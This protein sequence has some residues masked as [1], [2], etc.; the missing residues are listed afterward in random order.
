MKLFFKYIKRYRCTPELFEM[1]FLNG[2]LYPR[3]AQ[4]IKRL[5][6]IGLRQQMLYSH[7][8][9]VQDVYL[10]A[11]RK[12]C[13]SVRR[14]LGFLVVVI[15]PPQSKLKLLLFLWKLFVVKMCACLV[16]SVQNSFLQL[17]LC[18]LTLQFLNQKGIT[19][20]MMGMKK[21]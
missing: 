9:S 11:V 13:S 8:V 15:G 20:N 6:P 18:L 1:F 17:D 10:G 12:P 19:E 4:R 16:F 21:K 3:V 2:D 7:K 5:A 14:S